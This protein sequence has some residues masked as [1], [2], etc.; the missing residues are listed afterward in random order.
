[1]TAKYK[2]IF[3]SEV[4]VKMRRSTVAFHI[5]GMMMTFL[6]ASTTMTGAKENN[7]LDFNKIV[8]YGGEWS[9]DNSGEMPIV[10]QNKASDGI[11]WLLFQELTV[12]ENFAFEAELGVI[13]GNHPEHRPYFGLT[14]NDQFESAEKMIHRGYRF[15]FRP[16]SF[17]YELEKRTPNSEFLGFHTDVTPWLWD[18]EEW[19]TLRIE[20]TGGRVEAFVDG[21]RIISADDTDYIGGT[22]GFWTYSTAAVFRNIRY[23]SP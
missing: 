6:I 16:S 21:E 4:D 15:T 22:L 3:G 10:T 9:V 13:T 19:R 12:P 18:L 5:V 2:F 14:F 11:T 8:T 23:E 7:E 20:R 1:M 17:R